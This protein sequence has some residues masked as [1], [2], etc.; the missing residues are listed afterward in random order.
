MYKKTVIDGKFL[1]I[2]IIIKSL[3]FAQNVSRNCIG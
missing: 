2:L 3:K 1:K